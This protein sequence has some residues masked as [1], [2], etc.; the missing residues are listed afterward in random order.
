[1]KKIILMILSLFLFV[2]CATLSSVGGWREFATKHNMT[3]VM[4][5]KKVFYA[6][7][8]DPSLEQKS[9]ILYYNYKP[10]TNRDMRLMCYYV[11]GEFYCDIDSFGYIDGYNMTLTL[12][13]EQ[14]RLVNS[15][16]S[17]YLTQH[18]IKYF[19]TMLKYY[20]ANLPVAFDKDLGIFIPY[21]KRK[22]YLLDD[23]DKLKQEFESSM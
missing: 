20:R 17:I 19:T 13:N 23:I 12:L 15:T 2:S 5:T 4:D 10:Y 16:D 1:M 9:Y 7:Y 8:K 18:G 6:E 11:D 3:V 21:N 14:V 22:E